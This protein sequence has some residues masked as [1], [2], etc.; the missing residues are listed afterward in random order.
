MYIVKHKPRRIGSAAASAARKSSGSRQR[1][2][3]AATR[4][5]L[6]A[7]AERI[8]ARDGFAAARLEDIA[9]SAG[10]T[11][12]AFYANFEDKEDLFFALLEHWVAER[13]AHVNALLERCKD[14]Q[15][16]LRALRDYYA[17]NAKDR[18]FT[19]LSLEFSLYAVRHPEAHA[20]LRARR[21]NLRSCGAGILRK[22]MRSLGRSLPVS[23]VAASTGLGALSTSL[24]LEHLVDP[25]SLDE[26][27]MRHLLGAFFD[28]V[29]SEHK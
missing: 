24:L 9:A 23:A 8:F 2:R 18:R 3:T 7:A 14:A 11:R 6:L 4:Q 16:M 12:G 28:A 13:V 20:R 17:R 27:E 29:V 19:L 10:Y 25:K 26:D 1:A 15:E 21:Q 5:K 22:I